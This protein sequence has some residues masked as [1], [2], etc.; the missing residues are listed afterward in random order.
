MMAVEEFI[1][2]LAEALP[3]LLR[4]PEGL[5]I[6]LS[7]LSVDLPVES[8]IEN[9]ARLLVCAPRGRM[10]TWFNPQHG[11]VRVCFVPEEA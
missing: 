3:G 5:G 11:R 10:L 8:R 4:Q 7:E 2:D 6:G 9:E 1:R